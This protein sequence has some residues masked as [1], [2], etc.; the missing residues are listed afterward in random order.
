MSKFKSLAGDTVI[1]G[2]ST[3]LVRLLNWL[4]MPYYIRTLS[5]VEYGVV[6]QMYGYIAV[7]LVLLTYGFETAFFR[8][9]KDKS[10]SKVFTTAISSI[11]STSLLFI[12]LIVYFNDYISSL[13][14]FEGLNKI[15]ILS[16]VF[17]SLDAVTSILF[18]K[19]RFE[20]KRIKFAILKLINVVVII[21][22]NLLFLYFIPKYNTSFLDVSHP[23]VFVFISNLIASSFIFIILFPDLYRSYTTI[24][25]SLLKKMFRYSFPILIVGITGMINMHVDKI[26]IPEIIGGKE[27]YSQLAIYSANFKIGVLMAMFTQSFRL[28]FEPF[29]F[30]HDKDSGDKSVYATILNYFVWFGLFIFL[31]VTF[32]IDI[33]NLLLVKDYIVGN[34]IIPV[35]LIAQLFSGIYFTLSVWYKLTDKTIYGAYMSVIG[36]VFSVS[37]NFIL[38]P[39]L[40]IMGAALSGLVCFFV[41]FILSAYWGEKHFSVNYQWLKII[42]YFIFVAIIY[43]V[44]VYLVPF[45]LK[46]IVSNTIL[47][48]IIS[49]IIRTLLILFFVIIIY[50]REYKRKFI[51]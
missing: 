13:F 30:K 28:A 38:I 51:V 25:F 14:E 1:Y 41:M 11:F 12:F 17:V 43:S 47:Y 42:Y 27:G 37:L 24:D 23:S 50:F 36:S 26:L 39:V 18:V 20:G 31:G 34:E 48:N 9:A 46:M 49:F 10:I 35:V 15:I 33:I 3:I 29:F 5:K 40:G 16:A 45:L 21:F 19:L 32:Y 22:F 7:F 2:A 44:G 6:N 4:L 8:F